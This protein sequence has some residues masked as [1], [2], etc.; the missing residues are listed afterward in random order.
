[1]STLQEKH[2]KALNLITEFKELRSMQKS[3][4]QQRK[5]DPV[6]APDTLAKCKIQEKKIDKMIV[7]FETVKQPTLF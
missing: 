1:M 4:F 6:K 7:D 2:K 3:F 5:D